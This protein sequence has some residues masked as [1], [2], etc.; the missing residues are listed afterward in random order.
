MV[1]KGLRFRIECYFEYILRD[2]PLR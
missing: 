2:S 1:R